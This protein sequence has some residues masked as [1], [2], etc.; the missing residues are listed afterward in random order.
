MERTV[1]TYDESMTKGALAPA[2][3]KRLTSYIDKHLATTLRTTHLAAT[4]G[5]SVSHFSRAFKQAFGVP[6]RVYILRRR[7]EAA[8]SAMLDTDQALTTIA[9]AHGFCD[10]S[11]FT[12]SFQHEIGAAP[13]EWRRGRM[14]NTG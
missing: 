14:L 10:H 11:H 7:I 4:L 12:R 8:C 3:I 1:P 6:P 13:Q 2:H 5:L 9:L